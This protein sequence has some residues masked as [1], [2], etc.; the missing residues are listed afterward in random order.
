MSQNSPTAA[1]ERRH[2]FPRGVVIFFGLVIALVVVL[3]LIRPSWLGRD[4]DETSTTGT[5]FVQDLA[6]LGKPAGISLSDD[7][8][9]SASF[10]VA[11]PRDS[12][13]QTAELTLV[14]HTQA[15]SA[16]TVFL[17]VLVDGYSQYVG[18]L[19]PGEH[20]LDVD[21]PVPD[22]ALADGSVR[23]QV[24]LTGG[25][26]QQQCNLDETLGALVVLDATKTRLHG[27]LDDPLHT[28]RDLV[29]GLEHDVTLD[30]ALPTTGADAQP[31]LETA[32]QLGVA[33]TQEGHAVSFADV[34]DA[35]S[36][37]D[38]SHIL[39]GPAD[40]VAD[41]GWQPGSG[42]GG[43][44]AVG[45]VEDVAHLAVIAT[46]SDVVPTF[47]ATDP[48]TTADAPAT[49]PESLQIERPAGDEVS[50]ESIGASTDVQQLID[51][52]SWRV[53]FSLS[54]LPGGSV[55]TAVRLAFQVPT[56]TDDARW[57]VQVELNGRQ[58]GS[59]V[60]H[61]SGTQRV[62][63]AIPAGQ[64][65]VRNQLTVTLIRDRDLGG[66]NVRTPTYDVQLLP[67][68]ALVL[69]GSDAG[70]T[71]V[72]A[73]FSAGF[74]L[75]IPASSTEAPAAT[76]TGLVP[77]LAEFSGWQQVADFAWD[78]APGARPFLA[79]GPVPAGVTVPVT[80]ADGRLTGSGFDLQSFTDGLVVQLVS[81]PARTPGL[82]VTPV[83]DAADVVL[84]AFGRESARVIATDGGGFVV[85]G[86]G[87]VVVV[88]STRSET[89]P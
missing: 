40:A 24:K 67:E 48:V 44:V 2:W 80:V 77:T 83:G 45:T 31:W 9:T 76:L 81:P 57:L 78:G 82:V 17:R 10:T 29:A 41:L 63:V 59:P 66:C 65:L 12:T 62:T 14:G 87:R 55:P 52:S 42:S 16:G 3:A 79:F 23:V 75:D 33:L 38:G 26:D 70:F 30:L 18:E 13:I 61:G 89:T 53:P 54:D 27:P 74:D 46:S 72:P 56:V 19:D 36:G 71:A 11:V 5:S 28:V 58:I 51:S 32:A 69:G 88:P 4:D 22:D 47:L 8:A 20:D 35:L 84:P 25:L 1:P 86:S 34:T 49:S 37:G 60:L 6:G 68:S 43:T 21:V 64:E 85:D 73:G 7:N 50:L 39:V 15:S